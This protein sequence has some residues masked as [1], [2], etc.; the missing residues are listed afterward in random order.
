MP[1]SFDSYL[2]KL[3]PWEKL[4]YKNLLLGS[5]I[6][7]VTFGFALAITPIPIARLIG[8]W[9]MLIWL[10][11]FIQGRRSAAV[12]IRFDRVTDLTTALTEETMLLLLDAAK[13]AELLQSDQAQI[14]LL[15][16]LLSQREVIRL[17]DRFNLS[18]R[19]LQRELDTYVKTVVPS[20]KFSQVGQLDLSLDLRQRLAKKLELIVL[21]A[22]NLAKDLAYPAITPS[23]LLV[24]LNEQAEPLLEELFQKF[25]LEKQFLRSALM[26]NL[27]RN[28]ISRAGL[29]PTASFQLRGSRRRWLNRAWTTRPTPLL[30]QIGQD[31]TALARTGQIG[32]LIGHRKE[33]EALLRLLEQ[34][35]TFTSL[36]IGRPGSGKRSLV[37]RLAWLISHDAVPER[38]FDYRLI[39]LNLTGLFALDPANFHQ[40]LLAALNEAVQARNVIIF[41]PDIEQILLSNISPTPMSILQPFFN[42][43][44]FVATTTPEAWPRLKQ[45]AAVENYFHVIELTELSP[46]EAITFLTLQALILEKNNPSLITPPAIARAVTLAERFLPD[47]PLPASAQEVLEAAF[48]FA[49]RNKIRIITDELISDIV[50]NLAHIPATEPREIEQ[51]LLKNLETI[52]HQRIVDQNFAVQ[53]VVRVLRTYRSGLVKNKGPIGTFLFVGPTGVGKTE[54]AKTLARAYFGG[55]SE[56]IRIDLVEFQT[57]QDLERLIGS[58]DGQ[59]IGLLTE[60][61]RHKPYSLILLDEFEKAD[62]EILNLFLPI[63]DDGYIKDGLG[64]NINFTNTIIIAT[65]NACSDLIH[66]Q[67]KQG[68]DISQVAGFVREKLTDYFPIEL[69]NRF[70]GIIFFKPLTPTELRQIAE[71][72]VAD[73]NQELMENFGFSLNLSNSAYNKLIQL[74][75]DPTYGARPLSRAF[76]RELK[77]PLA[78]LVL[79]KK[80][81]RGAQVR[82]EANDQGFNFTWS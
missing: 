18:P 52:L 59:I 15:N 43:L 27:F 8:S 50:S 28:Q 23:L 73:L 77:G 6:F 40:T 10:F 71:I 12:D 19:E 5:R 30:D 32:F 69:L 35:S 42:Q 39:E 34:R 44:S 33:I 68:R 11:H 16:K 65:S 29:Q 51:Y 56:L 25:R 75:Y 45:Q 70:D 72:I 80:I 7:L 24:A 58:A 36:L 55:D 4:L 62:R 20:Q 13:D 47:K 37:W 64:R 31:L 41:L 38:Y 1:Q 57:P 60:A 48:A 2:L 61:V 66:E 46:I 79:D 22:Y 9:L 49:R 78:T 82:V 67:L 21:T 74:G 54:L 81:P 63:F 53:E 14:F 3:N 26:M 17:F 76:E